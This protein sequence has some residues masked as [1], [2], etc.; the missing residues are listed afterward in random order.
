MFRTCQDVG[1]VLRLDDE[2][3]RRYAMPQVLNFDSSR[4]RRFNLFD[5]PSFGLSE[6]LTFERSKFCESMNVPSYPGE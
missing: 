5:Q 1:W 6:P 2:R 3:D 4:D